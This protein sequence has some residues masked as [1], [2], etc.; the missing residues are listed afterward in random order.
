MKRE[1]L[2][3]EALYGPVPDN[4]HGRLHTTLDNLKE[5]EPVKK[6]RF[7]PLLVAL[8]LILLCG[9]A[10]AAV[11][12]WGVR[13]ALTHQSRSGEELINET[14]MEYAQPV[15]KVYENNVLRVEVTDAIYD[16]ASVIAAWT[17]TNLTDE[18]LY[19]YMEPTEDSIN[20]NDGPASFSAVDN[21]IKPGETLNGLMDCRVYDLPEGDRARVGLRYNVLRTAAEIAYFDY[22]E[23]G[24]MKGDDYIQYED[25]TERQVTY[26]EATKAALAEGKLALAVFPD[27]YLTFPDTF[28]SV[29][30]EPVYEALDATGKF[31][32]MA[33][34]MVET[35]MF[36]PASTLDAAFDL[37]VPHNAVRSLL[38]GGEMPEM[39]YDELTMRIS[40]ADCS[41][42]TLEIVVDAIYPDK[43]TADLYE[44]V[45]FVGMNEEGRL[46]W[47]DNSSWG[48]YI[49]GPVEQEDGS[50]LMQYNISHT[51]MMYLP[52]EILVCPRITQL[53]MN[54]A[55]GETNAWL[56][57]AKP[58]QEEGI[59]LY[60]K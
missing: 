44:N 6:M 22:P 15:G 46:D 5:D 59:T 29:A 37:Q 53:N 2:D 52:E 48:A 36:A 55:P 30:L 1:K 21:F 25:G 40:K 56:V 26:E 42:G 7:Q 58:G 51:Q 39:V 38:P 13:E 3:W 23:M 32:S 14:L 24:Y 33:D 43:E 57:T 34:A 4:V 49:P 17:V 41:P 35:G 19:I 20:W 31:Y 54:L 50:W 47:D 60:T 28:Y 10:I 27:E 9:V 12:S 16:G 45:S 18:L 11:S 8:I